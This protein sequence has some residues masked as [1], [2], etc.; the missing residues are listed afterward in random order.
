M[1]RVQQNKISSPDKETDL[2]LIEPNMAIIN[3]GNYEKQP[4]KFP[5]ELLKLDHNDYIRK[6]MT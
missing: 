4:A 2:K 1:K 6:E 5:P 3:L